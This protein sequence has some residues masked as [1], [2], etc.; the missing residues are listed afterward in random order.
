MTKVLTD[1]QL[2]D[3]FIE[4]VATN[5]YNNSHGVTYWS[6]LHYMERNSETLIHN[7]VSAALKMYTTSKDY[8]KDIEYLE[9][10]RR[11]WAKEWEGEWE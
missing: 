1:G 4:F 3:A 2:K 7:T 5:V 10:R 6:V 11:E 8:E 9:E